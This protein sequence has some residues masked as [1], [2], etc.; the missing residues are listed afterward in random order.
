MSRFLNGN[1]RPFNSGGVANMTGTATI[2]STVID[3]LS[4][5][6]G[7][8]EIQAV[9]TGSGTLTVEGS[10]RYDAV[11]N[12]NA[13]FVPLTT[14]TS[15]ALPAPAGA[16]VAALCAWVTQA[17]GCRYVRLRYVNASGSG[18]LDVYH[19]GQGVA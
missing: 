6:K 10:N 8:L 15:P 1:N 9:G 17:L 12:P 14:P 19:S 2:V 13:V 11:N 7:T 5:D 18:T 16:N 3:M 4:I